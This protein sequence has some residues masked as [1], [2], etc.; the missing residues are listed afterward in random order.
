LSG[1]L[2][3]GGRVIDPQNGVDEIRDLLIPGLPDEVFNAAGKIVV[4]AL[5]DLHVHF[6]EPGFEYKE[7]IASGSKAAARGGFCRVCMMPNTK[8][9]VDNPEAVRKNQ[10][11]GI[12]ELF[13]AGA[14]SKAQAGEELADLTGMAGLCRCFSDDGKT[15]ASLELMREAAI[16]TKELGLFISDHCEPE[17]EIVE[18]DIALAKETGCHFHLQHISLKESVALIREAKRQGLPI[19]AETAPHYF[20][21]TEDAVRTFG[22]NAKMNPPLRTESDRLAIIEGIKDGVF[23]CIA[24][25]HAPHSPEEKAKPLAEAPNGIVGLETAFAVS[26]TVLVRGGHIGI[27]G[28]IRLMGVNPANILGVKQYGITQDKPADIAVF[29]I[30]TPYNISAGEFASKSR[31]TPFEGMRVFG[32]TLLTVH[33]GRIIYREAEK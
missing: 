19:T 15:L 33:N 6:R 2:I 11:G 31:N 28:L 23:D 18:R 29:D 17:H 25:D 3:Q 20:A 32:R 7:D 30:D 8:P 9:A 10:A 21:L 5:T 4:P 26:Y 24:T 16:K 22:A 14:L 27:N 13:L 12:V 1:L